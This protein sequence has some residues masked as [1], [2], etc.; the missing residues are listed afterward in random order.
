MKHSLFS[1]NQD[2]KYSYIIDYIPPHLDHTGTATFTITAG[3]YAFPIE[4]YGLTT[5]IHLRHLSEE[6]VE[7]CS[8][9]YIT[10]ED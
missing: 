9:I 2:H 10:D 5:Y 1:P 4:E 7:H 8:I 6:K 3:Y